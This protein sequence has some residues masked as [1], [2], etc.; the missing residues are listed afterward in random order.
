MNFSWSSRSGKALFG[1]GVD[2]SISTLNILIG[3]A[4]VPVYLWFLSIE[5]FGVWL[6]I[7]SIFGILSLADFG[8]LV[9]IT[10]EIAKPSTFSDQR[11]RSTLFSTGVVVQSAFAAIFL[12]IGVL[13][14]PFIRAWLGTGVSAENMGN[15]SAAYV[16]SLLAF[17]LKFPMS[18]P[19]AILLG[20]QHIGLVNLANGLALLLSNLLAIL[21]LARGYGILSFAIALL[22]SNLAVD[23]TLFFVMRQKVEGLRL[24]ISKDIIIYF[25]QLFRFALSFQTI[26]FANVIQLYI[27]APIIHALLGPAAVTR[28]N[29]TNRIPQSIPGNV[30]R[31]VGALYP[32]LCEVHA[33]GQPSKLHAVFLK[34]SGLAL[35]LAFFSGIAVLALSQPFI[36]VWVG[37]DKYAG[38]PTLLLLSLMLAKELFFRCFGMFIYAGNSFGYWPIIAA[39]EVG[40]VVL[41]A[42]CFGS[43]WALPGIALGFF[44]ATIP[45]NLYVLLVLLRSFNIT[46]RQYLGFLLPVVLKST[47]SLLLGSALV[48]FPLEPAWSSLF[49]W[50]MVLL[51]INLAFFELPRLIHAPERG[52]KKRIIFAIRNA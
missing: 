22:I 47:P 14:H 38:F 37:G 42:L 15:I 43:L 12:T 39:I 16:I 7:Y 33:E 29:I 52:L 28:Y 40:A 27:T 17:V 19:G 3:L 51:G 21:P 24:I 32:A 35:R 48:L 8:V 6:V 44:L 23:L 11:T 45:S 36:S 31:A 4:V 34:L 30:S 9:W 20:R 41:L 26:K 25:K 5:D 50:G 18:V 2:L 46:V 49:G 10:R 1:A 13:L